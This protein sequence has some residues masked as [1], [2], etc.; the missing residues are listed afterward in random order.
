MPVTFHILRSPHYGMSTVLTDHE[1]LHRLGSRM[2]GNSRSLVS[3]RDKML[4]R[5]LGT[6]WRILSLVLLVVFLVEAV[7]M[8]LLPWILP[9]NLFDIQAAF[10]DAAMLTGICAPVLWLIIISPLRRIAL[11]AQALS[12]AIV[13]NAGEGI[14]TINS[15]GQILSFNPAAEVLFDH[16]A[17]S[18]LNSLI[19]DLL[20]EIRL[21]STNIGEAV[22]TNGKQRDGDYFPASVSIRR[23]DDNE[24]SDLVLVI[25]DLTEA[26]RAEAERTAAVREQEALRAQQMATLAQLATGVA[27]EI[28]NPLAAIKMLVQ[29]SNSEDD[30]SSMSNEDLRIVENQIRRMEQSVNALLDFARPAPTERKLIAIKEIVPDVVR[31]LE[32]QAEKQSVLL[33]VEEGVSE[34]T[35]N[36]DRDQ[37]Q[38]LLLNLGLNALSMMTQGGTLTFAV[39]SKSPGRVCILVSDTGPGIPEDLTDEIF[40]PF[41]TTR[42]QGIGLGLN[43]CKRIAEDHR[44][45]LS[46]YNHPAGGAIF[47]LCLPSADNTTTC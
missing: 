12:S 40:Q 4:L 8:L 35:L 32:G 22:A 46:A 43:I 36:A 31:L 39:K 47:E 25:R 9:K 30:E 34:L 16:H 21:D 29:S 20:P 11:D 17:K 26:K 38:Q 13:E 27:H 1:I 3:S 41:F 10:I 28:R 42:K 44:G 5:L 14:V 18:T 45:T 6:P 7:V 23:L 2:R 33:R 15:R 24:S 37:L 19:T